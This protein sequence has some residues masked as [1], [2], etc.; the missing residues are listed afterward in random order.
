MHHNETF[1]R[2]CHLNKV[3]MQ[4]KDWI[5]VG[6]YVFLLY[7]VAYIVISEDCCNLP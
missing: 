2:G 1:I 5:V 7:I 3:E 6:R 4:D